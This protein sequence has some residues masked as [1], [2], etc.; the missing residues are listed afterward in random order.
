M[1]V[2]LFLI[3]YLIGINGF[4]ISKT[5]EASKI[6]GVFAYRNY[7]KNGSFDNSVT[8]DLTYTTGG[9]GTASKSSVTGASGNAL[10]M[11]CV[12]AAGASCTNVVQFALETLEK[13]LENT[14]CVVEWYAYGS[15]FSSGGAVAYMEY[16]LDGA[17]YILGFSTG[18]AFSASQKQSLYV[19]CGTTTSTRTLKA[20]ANNTVTF[21]T[22][23]L[24]LDEVY[25]GAPRDVVDYPVISDWITFTPSG[26]WISNATYSGKYRRVGD[27]VEFQERVLASGTPTAANLTFGLP[28]ICTAIDTTKLTNTSPA[29]PTLGDAFGFDTG[30]NNYIGTVVYNDT[31]TIRVLSGAG[32]WSNTVPFSF[33]N[34]DEVTIMAKVPCTNL[35][36]GQSVTRQSCLTDGSCLNEFSAA[37]SATGTV[38]GENVDWINGNCS[39][40]SSLFTCNFKSGLFGAA[41]NCTATASSTASAASARIDTVPTTSLVGIRTFTTSTPANADYAFYLHCQRSTNDYKP[42]MPAPQYV[43]SVTNSNVTNPFRFEAASLVCSTASTITNTTSGTWTIGNYSGTTSSATCAV[44]F[45]KNFNTTPICNFTAVNWGNAIS[46]IIS[47]STTG[48]TVECVSTGANCTSGGALAGHLTCYGY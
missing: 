20:Y 44:T 4:A 9:T 3:A 46:Q 39:L 8:K 13:K 12:N 36:G 15:Y 47:P 32:V 1:R 5:V 38:S 24:N 45:N 14:T 21:S 41:P 48:V 25:F 16:V 23:S 10:N 31:T 22:T 17:T 26:S 29:T 30:V 37:V 2:F 11:Q 19:P 18:A 27:S 6:D 28:P 43:G 7:V 35:S 42:Q 40:A 33:G 34:T